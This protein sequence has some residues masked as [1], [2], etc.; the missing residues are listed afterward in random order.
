MDAAQHNKRGEQPKNRREHNV[1]PFPNKIQQGGWNELVGDKYEEISPYESPHQ[2]RGVNK[3]NAMG[4]K[5]TKRK[6]IT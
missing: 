3:V 1:L 4:F 2:Y 6:N 5:I